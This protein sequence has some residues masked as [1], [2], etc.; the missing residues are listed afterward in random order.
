MSEIDSLFIQIEAETQRANAE[1]DKMISKLGTLASSLTT[2]GSRL[3]NAFNTNGSP[4][5]S[6]QNLEQYIN[7][8]SKKMA[9]DLASIFN[10]DKSNIKDIEVATKSLAQSLS[11]TTSNGNN[12]Y[13][14][15]MNDLVSELQRTAQS[16]KI[17]DKDMESFYQTL[18]SV[19]H[20]KINPSDMTAENWKDLDG[21]LRGKLNTK[22]GTPLDSLMAEWREEYKG[23]FSSL[24]KEFNID[25]VNDQ[26]QALNVVCKRCREGITESVDKGFLSE[27][28]WDTVIEQSNALYRNIKDIQ[29]SLG[30]GST[31]VDNMQSVA[32]RLEELREKYKE[33]GKDFKFFGTNDSVQ[34]QIEK[35]SNSLE[36]AKLRK[37]QLEESDNTDS[38]MYEYAVRDIQ[39]CTNIIESLKNTISQP[40]EIHLMSDEEFNNLPSVKARLEEVRTALSDVDK[41]AEKLRTGKPLDFNWNGAPIPKELQSSIDASN[42]VQQSPYQNV[43]EDIADTREEISSF[44]N[45]LENIKPIKFE[46]NFYEMEKWVS[47]L[48]AKLLSL[49]DKQ[50]RLSSLGSGMDTQRM[51]GI[52]YD[53]EQTV[54]TLD[55]YEQKLEEARAAG[56]LEIRI[57][58]I[59]AS[60][61]N[62][63][64]KA[65]SAKENIQNIFAKLKIIVPTDEMT[66]LQKEIDKVRQQWQNTV[67]HINQKANTVQFYG[68]SQDFKNKQAELTALKNQYQEL[69]NKQ[70]E[71]AL[72]GGYRINYEAMNKGTKIFNESLQSLKNTLSK[73]N[74]ALARFASGLKNIILPVNAAKKSVNGLQKLANT[75]AKS[76]TRVVRMFKL[77]IT[78]M[79]LRSIIKGIGEGFKNAIQYSDQFNASVSLLWNSMRQLGNSI[80]AAAAPL[81][82]A[83]APALNYIIQLVI[84][85]V[86]AI[87]QLLSALTGGGTWLKAKKL[88]DDYGES[89]NKA[90]G[91]AN[92]ALQSFDKL[93]N[94]TSKSGGGGT[95][96]KDMFDE[97]PIDPKYK[98]MADKIKKTLED[99]F[100]P[101]KTSWDKYGNKVMESWKRALKEVKSLLKDVGRDFMEVWQQEA[102]QKIFEDILIIIADIGDV[103]ANIASNLRKAWNENKTGLHIFENIRDIIGVIIHN[104]RL[105]ADATVKWSEKLDFSPILTKIEEWTKSLIPVFD[106][107]SGIITDFYTTVLLPLGKWVLEKGLPDLLQVFIDFNDKVDWDKLRSNL[108]KLWEHL[109]PFAETV[110]EGLVI[111]IGRVSDALANF[112][113]SEAFQNFL[114]KLEKWMDDVSANDV[115]DALATI[116]K[117]IVGLKIALLGFKA[118]TSI[119]GILTTVTTFLKFFGSGKGTALAGEMTA[120]ASGINALAV[121]MVGLLSVDA[122]KNGSSAESFDRYR[123]SLEKFNHLDFKSMDFTDWKNTIEE[124]ALSTVGLGG[125][126]E[127]FNQSRVMNEMFES[128]PKPEDYECLDEFCIAMQEYKDKT[129]ELTGTKGIVEQFNTVFKDGKIEISQYSEETRKLCEQKWNESISE[130]VIKLNDA[131]STGK[132]PI[133]QLAASFEEGKLKIESSSKNISNSVKSNTNEICNNLK[134]AAIDMD[135]TGNQTILNLQ[136]KTKT[137]DLEFD[138][139][140]DNTVT[141]M[142]SMGREVVFNLDD[143]TQQMTTDFQELERDGSISM[144]NLSGNVKDDMVIIGNDLVSVS[145]ALDNSKGLFESFAEGVKGIFER[146]KD[147][148]SNAWSSIKSLFSDVPTPTA[149][150]VSLPSFSGRSLNIPE[151]ASGGYPD[152]GSLFLA[153]EAG[154]ELVGTLNHRTAVASNGEITGITDAVYNT[155]RQELDL[156]RQQNHL[157]QGILER[158]GITT[159]DIGR[160][161]ERYAQDFFNRTGKNAYSY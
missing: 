62:F 116:A 108:Q 72:S 147:W 127:H 158:T 135:K 70:K 104:I 92:K 82:N 19:Q 86:N 64:A 3:R 130:G 144:N 78:R 63:T 136:D 42:R 75:F 49:L 69:I 138:E 83:L 128:F 18:L 89:L 14:A 149:K 110:G 68:A 9:A 35:Y 26:V 126:V 88:T 137:W 157:L 141:T 57:P 155:S 66:R 55:V 77:M 121:G 47:E 102:T 133:S 80:A 44:Q 90:G 7:T 159:D 15:Q 134:M 21:A 79:I 98:D 101:I 100:K 99:L 120:A 95:S 1:L 142:D 114:E 97:E 105:A 38:R 33:L 22:V 109:E 112:V 46:G 125:T 20:I 31:S 131:V 12:D 36:N 119:T 37:E 53:I 91:S 145:P 153:N 25:S 84:N 11:N 28:I 58:P 139:L 60:F 115:A 107:L 24:E 59:D 113:N 29:S 8:A 93:N 13:S 123:E 30:T 6:V 61:E 161:S 50:E 40:Q 52:T 81:I 146:L 67:D 140:K 17:A 87:N 10:V 48:N 150:A 4:E 103:I 71:L 132:E 51:Q 16:A 111:F 122:I 118:I 94:I 148:L 129:Q 154:P 160:A 39:K 152:T 23:I 74:H 65:T 43:R 117:A 45:V 2:A 76:I 106:T 143:H 27:A 96:P 156:L 124:F 73:I 41:E 56:Q 85:A 54:K 34:R 151:Y 5:K 32:N